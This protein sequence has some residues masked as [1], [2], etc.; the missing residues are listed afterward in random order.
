MFP[1]RTD[2]HGTLNLPQYEESERNN[3]LLHFTYT[4]TNSF[5]VS[6]SK[7]QL[8]RIYLP[9]F[10]RHSNSDDGAPCSK[11]CDT[12]LLSLKSNEL[13]M[14]CIRKQNVQESSSNHIK[15]AINF[16]LVFIWLKTSFIAIGSRQRRQQKH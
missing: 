16:K 5:V 9:F 10:R 15:V 8:M 6:L 2:A 3:I 12:F 11:V 4:T 13:Y 14:F 1:S 7:T